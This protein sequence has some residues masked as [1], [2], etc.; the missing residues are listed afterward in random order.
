MIEAGCACAILMRYMACRGFQIGR[1]V[2]RRK[3]WSTD[4]DV[5]QEF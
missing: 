3:N 5:A 4:E 2:D 1:L